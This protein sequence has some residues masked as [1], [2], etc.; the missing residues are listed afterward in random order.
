MRT[1]V[2]APGS[3]SVWVRAG[4]ITC[5]VKKTGK[6]GCTVKGVGEHLVGGASGMARSRKARTSASSAGLVLWPRPLYSRRSTF[7]NPAPHPPPRRLWAATAAT[8][9]EAPATSDEAL[10]APSPS[11]HYLEAGRSQRC[12]EW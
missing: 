3:Q 10:A 6:G 4:G 11:F 12:I 2:G 9:N 7:F 5:L 1:I 8:S